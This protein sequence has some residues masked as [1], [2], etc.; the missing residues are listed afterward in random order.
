MRCAIYIFYNTKF[1]Q[2]AMSTLM[3][4]LDCYDNLGHTFDIYNVNNDICE[5]DM[6]ENKKLVAMLKTYKCFNKM[7]L[8][9]IPESHIGFYKKQM[10]LCPSYGVAM[11]ILTY[12]MFNKDLQ[13]YDRVFYLDADLLFL[14]PNLDFFNNDFDIGVVPSIG[15]NFNK[16]G[17]HYVINKELNY[18]ERPHNLNAGFFCIRAK[19]M[20]FRRVYNDLISFHLNWFRTNKADKVFE[21]IIIAKYMKSDEFNYKIKCF[22]IGN[23]CLRTLLHD[24]R[25]DYIFSTFDVNMIHYGSFK[26][27][28]T[29]FYI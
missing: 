14:K 26:P 17:R 5:L 27:F 22:G 16:F 15:N 1:L 8:L 7:E 21:Q 4:F 10:K 24:N 3:S 11:S 23:N 9:D 25:Y 6:E 29:F 20:D 12:E 18:K 13:D 19:S 2:G 28:L